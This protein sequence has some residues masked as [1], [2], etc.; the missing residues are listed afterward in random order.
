M[1]IHGHGHEWKGYTLQEGERIY[2]MLNVMAP[3][4]HAGGKIRPANE[5]RG[6]NLIELKRRNHEVTDVHAQPYEMRGA[7][8]DKRSC[9]KTD[10]KVSK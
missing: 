4:T 1:L 5:R 10:W 9:H 2:D 8:I 3:S 6:F 7:V